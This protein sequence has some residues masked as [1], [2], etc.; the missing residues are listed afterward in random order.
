MSLPIKQSDLVQTKTNTILHMLNHTE[1]R[2][3]TALVNLM[4]ISQVSSV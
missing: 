2:H 3:T 1:D 4:V